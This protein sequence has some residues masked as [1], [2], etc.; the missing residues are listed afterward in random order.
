MPE[1]RP[2]KDTYCGGCFMAAV[3]AKKP[4]LRTESESAATEV[5]PLCGRGTIE[6]RVAGKWVVIWPR[7]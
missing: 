3:R 6:R 5:C 4:L 2:V 7:Q 1:T